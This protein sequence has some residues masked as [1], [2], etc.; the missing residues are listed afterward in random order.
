[1]NINDLELLVENLTFNRMT[2][3]V[4]RLGLA[5][6]L[7]SQ[8]VDF[9]LEKFQGYEKAGFTKE[10]VIHALLEIKKLLDQNQIKKK[11]NV[12]I[13]WTGPEMPNST[14]RDTSVVAQ[15]LFREADHEVLVAGFAFYQGKDLFAEVAKKYDLNEA[16]K[17]TIVVDVRRDG[18]TSA[19]AAVLLKFRNDFLAK[20]WP[21]KRAP[22]IY[23]DPR[24]L[25]LKGFNKSS[26]HAK[27]IVVDARK[28]FITSANFTAAA[29]HRNIEAGVII[30]SKEHAVSLQSQFSNLIE[31]GILRKI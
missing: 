29:H 26:M 16:F 17:V 21:G 7:P 14:L 27:C 5:D 9:W 18:N 2:Y 24:T 4:S 1:M 10:Q 30:E 22:D 6:K 8:K 25:S 3:P 11:S 28:A 20:Q 12:E 19:E 15:E 31:A 23:F 13:V